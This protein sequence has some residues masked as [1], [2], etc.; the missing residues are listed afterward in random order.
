MLSETISSEIVDGMR[1]VFGG[2]LLSVVLYGS[3][4]RGDD[5][6]ESDVDI[7]VFLREPMESGKL[8][9]MVSVF[10]AL[11]LKYDRVFSPMDIEQAMFDKWVGVLSYYQNIRKEG[12]VL[13][14]AAA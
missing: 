10:A 9:Q 2:Q 8:D 12:I 3:V 6:P 1:N 7:A 14:K 5:T 13:W 11:G 4:A